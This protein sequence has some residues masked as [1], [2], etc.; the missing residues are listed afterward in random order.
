MTLDGRYLELRKEAEDWVSALD[1]NPLGIFAVI[2]KA[3]VCAY[4]YRLVPYD[5]E[6]YEVINDEESPENHDINNGV[7]DGSYSKSMSE[8]YFW[9]SK[10]ER[11]DHRAIIKKHILGVSKTIERYQTI[12]DNG[13]A[14]NYFA[15]G[16]WDLDLVDL[17]ITEGLDASIAAATQ[18]GAIR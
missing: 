12:Y 16:I 6:L 13:H 5:S 3:L 18:F 8:L 17:Y 7:S 15:V 11:A 4:A 2:D 1:R 14:H 9:L 10:S